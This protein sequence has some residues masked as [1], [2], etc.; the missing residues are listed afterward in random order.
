MKIAIPQLGLP[1]FDNIARCLQST[2]SK[3][4]INMEIVLW[5]PNV[6][7]LIDLFDEIWPDLIF[8]HEQIL[9]PEINLV[10]EEFDFRYV[11]ACGGPNDHL[12]RRPDVVLTHKEATGAFDPSYKTLV[13]SPVA[14]AISMHFSEH[15]ERVESDILIITNPQ[16][17]FTDNLIAMTEYLCHNYRTKI[18]GS[19]TVDNYHYLGAVSPAER[20]SFIR[21]TKLVIDLGS[22]EFLDAACAKVP[23]LIFM[24]SQMESPPSIFS[25]FRSFLTLKELKTHVEDLLS[26]D[27]DYKAYSQSCYEELLGH[28]ATTFHAASD[29]FS[30]LGEKHISETLLDT[31]KEFVL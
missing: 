10:L 2:A 23:S 14:D 16:I 24:G 29:I 25:S 1:Y 4:G 13:S 22:Y 30:L 6:K 3:P 27:D 18:I 15:D 21:S 9:R 7:P 28:R 17:Q 11:L 19:G 5:N 31:L 26:T 20:A 12:H 8:L